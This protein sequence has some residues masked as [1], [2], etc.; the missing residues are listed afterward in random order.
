M[1]HRKVCLV[2]DIGS[3]KTRSLTARSFLTNVGVFQEV[4]QTTDPA[5][6]FLHEHSNMDGPK[7]VTTSGIFYLCGQ[8]TKGL[9]KDRCAGLKVTC[10]QITD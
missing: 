5:G 2:R 3:S 4:W 6:G 10:D 9:R 7:G 8:P 1:F